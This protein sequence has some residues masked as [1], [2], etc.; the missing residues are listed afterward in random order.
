MN[1]EIT[2]AILTEISSIQTDLD[3]TGILKETCTIICSHLQLTFVGLFVIDSKKE[4]MVFR[5]GSGKVGEILQERGHSLPTDG[6]SSIA[7]CVRFDEVWITNQHTGDVFKC[8]LP[9]KD[10]M[11]TISKFELQYVDTENWFSSP[12]IPSA[13]SMSLP[14]RING[15]SFGAFLIFHEDDTFDVGIE[16]STIYL[17]TLADEITI[18]LKNLKIVPSV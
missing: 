14:L 7:T 6:E 3:E 18:V 8:P 1:S 15:Q 11:E 5:A 2:K 9:T 10:K 17:Q 16:E 13:W 4:L 12:L